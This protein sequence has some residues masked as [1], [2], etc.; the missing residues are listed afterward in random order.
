MNFFLGQKWVVVFHFVILKRCQMIRVRTAGRWVNQRNVV[1]VHLTIP[2]DLLHG[3]SATTFTIQEFSMCGISTNIYP[4]NDPNADDP[5]KSWTHGV[6][7][8]F[9]ERW[10]LESFK[11]E[12]SRPKPTPMQR[13]RRWTATLTQHGEE[14][15]KEVEHCGYSKIG[16]RSSF[17]F[18]TSRLC[19]FCSRDIRQSDLLRT[20]TGKGSAI[21]L[22]LE[23]W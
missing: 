14:I 8:T 3:K 16:R 21:V 22:N 4:K 19:S 9:V 18:R 7:A 23:N 20:T 17:K 2:Q 12:P 5:P 15:R 11:E 13:P 1:Q 10:S 6:M